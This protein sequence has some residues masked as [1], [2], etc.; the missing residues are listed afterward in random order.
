MVVMKHMPLLL[1]HYFL[2]YAY[3]KCYTHCIFRCDA[4]LVKSR[5]SDGNRLIEFG[6]IAAA[7]LPFTD[8]FQESTFFLVIG[9][10]H[11]RANLQKTAFCP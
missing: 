10:W 3:D 5:A 9:D 2:K 7:Y 4:L 6:K 1:L 11:L 8:K